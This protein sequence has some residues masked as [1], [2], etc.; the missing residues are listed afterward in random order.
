V[1]KD[2]KAERKAKEK[3]RR[4]RKIERALET[5]ARWS[6][7]PL[8]IDP[9]PQWERLARFGDPHRYS[10]GPVTVTLIRDGEVIYRAPLT[11]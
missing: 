9:L 8:P 7:P 2:S 4:Q 6:D 1:K 3:L 5:L 11:A 10:T